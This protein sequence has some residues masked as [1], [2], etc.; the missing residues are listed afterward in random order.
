MWMVCQEELSEEGKSP[1]S[2]TFT[3]HR[4]CSPPG[5]KKF[6]ALLDPGQLHGSQLWNMWGSLT[7]PSSS[8]FSPSQGGGL[9]T[10]TCFLPQVA[11]QKPLPDFSSATHIL[12]LYSFFQPLICYL[13]IAVCN[14][15]WPEFL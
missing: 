2:S 4:D 1:L 3:T 14:S 7:E 6:V 11:R 13:S 15:F 10:C 5:R 8:A 12:S 9:H